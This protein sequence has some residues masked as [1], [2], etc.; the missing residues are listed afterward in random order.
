VT[1]ELYEYLV[2]Y[3]WNK[4]IANDICDAYLKGDDAII[5]YAESLNDDEH[6]YTDEIIHMIKDWK[7]EVGE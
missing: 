1:E 5:Q 7:R 6:D 2:R 4:D 3:G